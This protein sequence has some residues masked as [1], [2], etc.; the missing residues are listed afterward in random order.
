MLQPLEIDPVPLG[1]APGAVTKMRLIPEPN[2]RIAIDPYPFDQPVLQVGVVHR[3]LG[4]SRFA[5]ES[6]FR[7]AYFEQPQAMMDFTFFDPLPASKR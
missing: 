5:D 3:R 7:K 2:R 4:E 1:Y 6:A